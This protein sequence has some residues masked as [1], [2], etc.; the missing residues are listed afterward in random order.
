MRGHDA[1]VKY[2]RRRSPRA[3]REI[4]STLFGRRRPG[5]N[6]SFPR[7]AHAHGEIPL[8]YPQP[9]PFKTHGASAIAS[10][11]PQLP[12]PRIDSVILVP[13]KTRFPCRLANATSWICGGSDK[14]S[15][16]ERC[17]GHLD[18]WMQDNPHSEGEGRGG[19][20]GGRRDIARDRYRNYE[21]QQHGSQ[22][23]GRKICEGPD[24]SRHGFAA[25]AGLE[26][27]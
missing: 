11:V 15:S 25:L 7:C 10:A 2:R 12:P 22:R 16:D 4:I 23:K 9:H 26:I 21:Q 14:R 19:Q 20:D 24:E 1:P 27:R 3:G 13:M 8:E 5:R 17:D 18:G 6:T